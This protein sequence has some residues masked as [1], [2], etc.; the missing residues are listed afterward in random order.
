MMGL[1]WGPAT[2]IKELGVVAEQCPYCE[3]AA[4]CMVRGVCEGGRLFFVRLAAPPPRETSCRCLG[5]DGAFPC[6]AWRYSAFVPAGEAAGLTVEHLLARTNPRLADRLEW[7][8]QVRALG[9]DARFATAYEQLE[10]MR[11]GDLHAQLQKELLDWG[12]LGEDQRAVLAQRV[13]S[14]YRAWQFARQ[15]APA[16]PDHAGCLSAFLAAAVVWL[17][18]AWAPVVHGWRWA[19]VTA[20]AGFVAAAV[21][22][23]VVLVRRVRRWTREVLVPEAQRAQ[24]SLPCF[25]A[26]VE[27]T[28]GMHQ[29]LDDL[30]SVKEQI[31]TIRAVL[32]ADGKL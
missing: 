1:H 12:R 5:C 22:G 11:L 19:F 13:G 7:N 30:W 17:A 27:D 31:D 3:R 24:V 23:R 32:A 14:C 20:F 16:F 9:G 15:V 21:V 28:P 2:E 4:P 25:L 8:E 6:Q 18:T 10:G 26:V 29:M